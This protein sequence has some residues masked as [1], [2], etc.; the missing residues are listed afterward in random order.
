[1]QLESLNRQGKRSDP[2]GY[3]RASAD[4]V[5]KHNRMSATHVR[6]FIR[7]TYL[8]KELWVKVDENGLS[9]Q[10]GADISFLDAAS[11]TAVYEFFYI[12]H[13]I[14]IDTEKSRRLKQAF[15]KEK[16]VTNEL[17]RAMF[18]EWRVDFC[19]YTVG[20]DVFELFAF[21]VKLPDDKSIRRMFV[22]YLRGLES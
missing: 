8:I 21:D 10:A 17:L 12:D 13:N 15:N 9:V 20:R 6:R 18:L 19:S 5:A 2:N 22:E 4:V 14:A 3:F 16:T 11:Q 7:L 1:M